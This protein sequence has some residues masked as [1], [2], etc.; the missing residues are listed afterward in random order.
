MGSRGADERYKRDMYM[1]WVH[2]LVLLICVLQVLGT[3]AAQGVSVSPIT[4]SLSYVSA[5][6]RADIEQLLPESYIFESILYES[7]I[8]DG[9]EQAQVLCGLHEHVLLSREDMYEALCRLSKQGRWTAVDI[10]TTKLPHGT[11][12]IHIYLRAALRVDHV[13]ITGSLL[14][15]DK[16]RQWYL[17]K[18]GMIFDESMHEAGM[19]KIR[20][21]LHSEGYFSGTILVH[22]KD[23][24]IH[25]TRTIYLQVQPGVRFCIE[26]VAVQMQSNDEKKRSCSMLERTIQNSVR[27]SLQKNPYTRAA[28]NSEMVSVKRMLIDQG[29]LSNSI[30]LEEHI[31]PASATVDLIFTIAIDAKHLFV[32]HGNRFFSRVQLLDTI[33]RFGESASLIPAPILAEEIRVL[34]RNKGFWNVAVIAEEDGEQV[35]FFIAEGRRVRVH[36]VI[37]TGAT[38]VSSSRLCTLF[39]K[40]LLRARYSDDRLLQD[41]RDAIVQWYLQQ[42]FWDVALSDCEYLQD[43]TGTCT[44]HM[45]VREGVQRWLTG[46]VRVDMPFI[47]DHDLAPALWCIDK[48]IPFDVAIIKRQKQDLQCILRKQGR[49]YANP[50]P[51]M[52][53]HE[54][55]CSITW[56]CGGV[57]EIVT[58]GKTIIQQ[59][60][61]VSDTILERELAYTE[62]A[63]WD[64]KQ[65]AITGDR[66]KGFGIYDVVTLVPDD[67]TRPELSKNLLLTCI[68]DASYEFRAR[69]GGQGVNRNVVQWRGGPSY[70]CGMS[71]IVRNPTQHADLLRADVDISRYMHDIALIYR[72][73]QV[74]S[75]LLR[76]ELQVFSSRY[77]QP[78][79]IG[80][81]E[82][83]YRIAQS[84]LLA[85]I[86]NVY[87]PLSSGISVGGSWDGLSV[88]DC[89][90][91]GHSI[92]SPL[93]GR[94]RAVACALDLNERLFGPRLLYLWLESTVL[95]DC[96]ND[97][98]NPSQGYITMG[99][100]KIV[101][102]PARTQGTFVKCLVE[103]SCFM[104]LM[105]NVV[106]AIRLRGGALGPAALQNVLPSERFYLGGPWSL[107]GYESDYAPPLNPL[108]TCSESR[109][110]VPTGGKAMLNMNAE[111]R[112]PLYHTLYGGVFFDGGALSTIG[113]STR[114]KP[115]AIMAV[116]GVGLRWNTMIGPLRFDIGWKMHPDHTITGFPVHDR[117]YAWFITLGHA[118]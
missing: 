94:E 106:L 52:R 76:T 81:P 46:V 109:C 17:I 36:A 95:F 72:I 26:T 3:I 64:V 42:G 53:E 49:L 62:G 32:F 19:R 58:F 39:G 66:I 101:L 29:F 117:R 73:P 45:A 105:R 16:Y 63:P 102:P 84:G 35:H 21:M 18:P 68:S 23:D 107:R 70:K 96:R 85:S 20:E 12:T 28:L 43:P 82:V 1:L 10:T 59:N 113:V 50:I 33:M 116:C 71:A 91:S 2:R 22:Y 41:M 97:S 25:K 111:L 115:H 54:A 86:S 77:D 114:V 83:L 60:S 69:L 9:I 65:L 74:F 57:Q 51:T 40:A 108:C 38:Y 13:S 104:L 100:I 103:Q 37:M 44:V 118:F 14:G 34:Y 4:F 93:C 78:L 6:H 99:A 48:P 87:G 31:K 89:S 15:K 75:Y 79:F 24:T 55:G 110:L 56:H 11:Y 90:S 7:D 88:T 5:D 112:F 27:K 47:H 67:I 98:V 30:T 8:A 80:S 61:T 92:R